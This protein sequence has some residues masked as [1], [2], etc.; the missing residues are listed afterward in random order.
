MP[1]V[2]DADGRLG[3][4]PVAVRVTAHPSR[5]ELTGNRSFSVKVSLVRGRAPSRRASRLTAAV[6]VTVRHQRD[7][8]RVGRALSKDRPCPIE[9]GAR[10]EH[11][12]GPETDPRSRPQHRGICQGG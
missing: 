1:P 10:V 5:R 8:M 2:V 4:L 11:D 7:G 9:S 3:V 6:T 12:R